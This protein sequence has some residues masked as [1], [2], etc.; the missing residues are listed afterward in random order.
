MLAKSQ[1]QAAL[2]AYSFAG[3]F[4]YISAVQLLLC[5]EHFASTKLC[6]HHAQTCIETRLILNTRIAH[7]RDNHA[8]KSGCW[9]TACLETDNVKVDCCA[10]NI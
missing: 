3:R 7:N 1:G 10:V 4:V 5:S 2:V 8:I 9:L 6:A